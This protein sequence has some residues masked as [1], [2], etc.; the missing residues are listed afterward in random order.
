MIKEI[1]ENLSNVSTGISNL[2]NPILGYYGLNAS[3]N[4]LAY[5]YKSFRTGCFYYLKSREAFRASNVSFDKYKALVEIKKD[6]LPNEYLNMLSNLY[7][8]RY[9]NLEGVGH[10]YSKVAKGI[11]CESIPHLF[12]GVAGVI[13]TIGI[14]SNF[15][16]NNGLNDIKYTK[17]GH[18]ILR[19]KFLD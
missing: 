8:N 1:K 18:A 7:F 10:N 4:N 2:I 6:V 9:I 17:E 13:L 12:Y 3:F 14:V 5:S 19:N 16:S 11:G 15:Y